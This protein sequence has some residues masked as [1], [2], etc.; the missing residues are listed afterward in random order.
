[1]ITEINIQR[2]NI[3]AMIKNGKRSKAPGGPRILAKTHN[4]SIW[5][6]LKSVY[7]PSA[8]LSPY[9]LLFGALLSSGK[10]FWKFV[11]KLKV[12]QSQ[13]PSYEMLTVGT[14][15]ISFSK[16]VSYEVIFI[17]FK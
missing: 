13:T 14:L 5:S 2:L 8:L 6:Q 1:M 9:N 3:T 16:I 17:T 11:C 15:P 12:N 7:Y 4:A 10:Y